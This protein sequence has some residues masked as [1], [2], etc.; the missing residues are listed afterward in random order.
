MHLIIIIALGIFGGLWMFTKWAEWREVRRLTPKM[1]KAVRS[2]DQKMDRAMNMAV[3]C[4]GSVFVVVLV[5]GLI[6]R[7]TS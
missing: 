5:I 2:F 6:V 3:V 1:P 7:A 4:G